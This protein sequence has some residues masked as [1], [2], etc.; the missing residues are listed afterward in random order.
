MDYVRLLDNFSDIT[1]ENAQDFLEVL[2]ASYWEHSGE[3]VWSGVWQLV[4]G[5]DASVVAA[6]LATDADHLDTRLVLAH[7][8]LSCRKILR[9]KSLVVASGARRKTQDINEFAPMR[10]PSFS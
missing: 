5:V 1:E 8:S 2:E 7:P 9:A 4:S 3:K 6:R 10:C